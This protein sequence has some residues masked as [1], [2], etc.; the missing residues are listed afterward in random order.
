MSQWDALKKFKIPRSTIKNKLKNHLRKRCGRP[1]IFS[2][3]EEVSVATHVEEMSE[4]GFPVTLLELSHIIKSH[5][6]E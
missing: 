5:V 1:A 2:K 4:D 6:D 3:E